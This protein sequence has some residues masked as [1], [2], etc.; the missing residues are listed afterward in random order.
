MATIEK[1]DSDDLAELLGAWSSGSGPLYIQLAVAVDHL[2]K[3]GQ[4]RD[5][6]ILPSERKLAEALSVSRSTVV[7][8]YD[9]LEECRRVDRRQGSGTRVTVEEVPGPDNRNPRVGSFFVSTSQS[10]ALVQ[11]SLPCTLDLRSELQ[12]LA[13]TVGTFGTVPR[14]L[15]MGLPELREA[16]ADRFTRKGLATS[17]DEI[18]ITSGCQQAVGLL[19]CTLLQTGDVAVVEEPTWPGAADVIER[20]GAR[21]FGVPV[22]SGGIDIDQLREVV[23]RLRPGLL[24]VNPHHQNP[25]STRLLPHRRRALADMSADYSIPLIEDR[26]LADL[27]FDGNVPPPLASLRPDAPIITVDSLSKTVW[28]GI[29]V[30][31]VRGSTDLIGRLK[32]EKAMSDLG[33]SLMPQLLA[34]QLES[35]LDSLIAKRSEMLAKRVKWASELLIEAVPDWSFEMPKGG[36]SF[37]CKLPSPVASG[38]ARHAAR[39]GLILVTD[40]AFSLCHDDQHIRVPFAAENAD[41]ANAIEMLADAWASFDPGSGPIYDLADDVG[42]NG[43]STAELLNR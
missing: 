36:A 4:L 24:V 31:W 19:V 29:G 16:I 42:W 2:V 30:G 9:R 12:E 33:T 18:L 11:A 21:V 3:N 17:S 34:C 40:K 37:W 20:V 5:G 41:Y 25:T 32:L 28:S 8:A 13:D 14:G 7:S 1:L 6:V 26:V 35:R 43:H 38:F 39:S 10:K 23:E 27:A 15:V 22:D